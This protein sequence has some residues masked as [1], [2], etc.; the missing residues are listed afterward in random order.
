MPLPT[1]CQTSCWCQAS[2]DAR[3]EGEAFWK[4]SFGCSAA[5]GEKN[6]LNPNHSPIIV[7]GT[8]EQFRSSHHSSGGPLQGGFDSRV[9][10]MITHILVDLYGTLRWGG[11]IVG[12]LACCCVKLHSSHCRIWNDVL[13]ETCKAK[14]FGPENHPDDEDDSDG[15]DPSG[16]ATESLSELSGPASSEH[17]QPQSVTD[18]RLCRLS[19]QSSKWSDHMTSSTASSST[20]SASSSGSKTDKEID[21]LVQEIKNL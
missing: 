11:Y 12:Y 17:L 14:D 7:A 16:A 2:Q 8:Y 18:K 9:W 19:L 5:F 20:R 4:W 10:Y 6:H 3:P 15:G 13:K 21:D 1:A